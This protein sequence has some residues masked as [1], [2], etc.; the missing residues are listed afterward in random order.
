MSHKMTDDQTWA[1]VFAADAEL[2]ACVRKASLVVMEEVTEAKLRDAKDLADHVV[3]YM[4]EK[5][6]RLAAIVHETGCLNEI[7]A[8]IENY[9]ME[10]QLLKE[11]VALRLQALQ[12]EKDEIEVRLRPYD[13]PNRA[14]LCLKTYEEMSIQ[15]QNA[16]FFLRILDGGQDA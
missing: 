9:P 4:Q 6:R 13:L 8:R 2:A 16:E 7:S 11:N 3:R 15:R 1:V 5:E 14:E 10:G 12:Q